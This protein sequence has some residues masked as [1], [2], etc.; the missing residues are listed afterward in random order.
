MFN[1]QN[2]MAMMSRYY[3]S[4]LEALTSTLASEIAV[5]HAL[6]LLYDISHQTM[7]PSPNAPPPTFYVSCLLHS[8]TLQM[9]QLPSP[10]PFLLCF[11]CPFQSC[12]SSS[13]EKTYLIEHTIIRFCYNSIALTLV[14]FPLRFFSA[15]GRN[16][17]TIY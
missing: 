10:S 4:F 8:G 12:V 17:G 2:C 13:L 3:D 16:K 14:C 11:S 7:F 6:V 1:I 9:F 15:V 5:T